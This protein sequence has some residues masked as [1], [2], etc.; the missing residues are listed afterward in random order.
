MTDLGSQ[1]IHKNSTTQGFQVM[2][3]LMR[4]GNFDDQ[5]LKSYGTELME[6]E[7]AA[8]SNGRHGA[9][10]WTH[11]GMDPNLNRTGEDSGSDPVIGYLKALS[12]S[13]DAATDFFNES[14]LSTNEDHDFKE[15]DEDTGKE[16]K[17]SLSNFNYLFEER[18]WPQEQDKD[19]NDS[20]SGR[21]N[22]AA[23]LEAA[24][25]GH[26]AGE[27]P[28]LDTP[29]HNAGQAELAKNLIASIS[30]DPK[31]LTEYS[32]MSDSVGQIAAE[33]MPDINRS[34]YPS[35]KVGDDLFPV[36]GNAARIDE[37]DVTR[38]LY[39]VGQNPE[40]YAAVNVGQAS[41]TT[42]L[43]EYHFANPDA[44]VAGDKTYSVNDNLK[45]AIED[46]ARVSAETQ[47][48]IGAGRAYASEVES[49]VKDQD[50]NDAI[51]TTSTWV[52]A[53]VG[54]GVGLLTAPFIGPGGIVAG[55]L[56]GT[57]AD[58]II[59]GISE[60]LI[61][62]STGEVI[63]RNGQ[64]IDATRQSTYTLVEAAAE[65]AGEG[66]KNS[67]PAIVAAAAVAAEQGF[68]NAHTNR[69]DYIDGEGNPQQL[70]KKE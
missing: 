1:P 36:V 52:G 56:A 13:P 31:R 65:K 54:I 53:G 20:I 27:L 51:E 40:G 7:K 62:D 43:M 47:G 2:S 23:A 70:E 41:Y 66:A 11:M 18:D 4:W 30:E 14:F 24:T 42:S 67:S 8:T 35:G 32:Y 22:L 9:T 45:Q 57:A 48:T 61:K 26:P 37:V 34:M 55:G 64:E 25:T 28:T 3:N 33:Y 10:V 12:N 21:N 44:F 46:V 19:N 69:K 49:G 5:F 58:E 63:Y 68:N 59:G 39:T 16:V 15:K 50:F 17:A 60:G 38:F 6:T 29:A